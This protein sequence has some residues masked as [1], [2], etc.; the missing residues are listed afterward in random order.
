ME[1]PPEHLMF[2]L[3]TTELHKVPATILSR[4]QRYSFK[5]LLPEDIVARLQYVADQ[6]DIPLTGEAANLLA[7]LSDGAMRDALSLMDQCRGEPIDRA[8]VLSVVG[9]AENSELMTIYE[10]VSRGDALTAIAVSYT[11]LHINL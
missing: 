5:R 2:I 7:R 10:S 11:H 4:C 3:A 9:L 8:R 6:E 1:E